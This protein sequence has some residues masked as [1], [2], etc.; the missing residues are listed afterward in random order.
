MLGRFD[1]VVAPPHSAAAT[2]AGAS[3]DSTAFVSNII[4]MRVAKAQAALT[5]LVHAQVARLREE[6]EALK[7]ERFIIYGTVLQPNVYCY[8]QLPKTL[9][10]P[11]GSIERAAMEQACRP[12]L[13]KMN[14][15]V[16]CTSRFVVAKDLYGEQFTWMG[17]L[18]FNHDTCA[19]RMGYIQI[20]DSTNRK[21]VQ[22]SLA[23]PTVMPL[24]P[25]DASVARDAESAEPAAPEPER[26]HDDAIMAQIANLQN[27]IEPS[28]PVAT[29]KPFFFS[30]DS[31]AAE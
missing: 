24:S 1:S 18:V 14:T 3:A 10:A 7:H 26:D 9:P 28:P 17:F 15:V 21:M 13:C 29:P 8:Y 16:V 4:D 30:D 6:V 5:D 31:K 27:I 20:R 25:S 23:P 2:A 19:I 12:Q 22:L 11:V